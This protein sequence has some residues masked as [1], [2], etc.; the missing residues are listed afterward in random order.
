MKSVEKDTVKINN[1]D[2]EKKEREEGEQYERDEM[3]GNAP[4]NKVKV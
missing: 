1:T 3:K 4:I 2:E